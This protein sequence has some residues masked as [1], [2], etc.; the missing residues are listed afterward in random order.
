MHIEV[1]DDASRLRRRATGIQCSD[2]PEIAGCPAQDNDDCG[3][4]AHECHDCGN[5]LLSCRCSPGEG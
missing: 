3:H 5:H 4:I 1:N 2:S